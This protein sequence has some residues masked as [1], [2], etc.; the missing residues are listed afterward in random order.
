MKY[1]TT[2]MSMSIK[3]ITSMMICM[4]IACL[5]WGISNH[6]LLIPGSILGI[7]IAFCYLWAPKGYE[8]DDNKLKIIYNFGEKEFSGITNIIEI[9][10]KLGFGIR[11]FGNGGVFCGTGIFWCRKIGIFRASVTSARLEDFQL[12]ETDKKK[13][14][15]SP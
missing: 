7:V 4:F 1:K 5:I 2:R 10:E 15:I 12:I 9:K 13:I 8:I 14:I 11:L 3:V 6:A